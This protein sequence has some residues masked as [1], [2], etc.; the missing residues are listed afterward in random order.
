MCPNPRDDR[1]TCPTGGCRTPGF[2]PPRVRLR[3]IPWW[4]SSPECATPNRSPI[5][6]RRSRQLRE[7]LVASYEHSPSFLKISPSAELSRSP[8][9]LF[10][11]VGDLL[12]ASKRSSRL[13]FLQLFFTL[14]PGS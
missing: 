12:I 5:R 3:L 4:I 11:I 1:T 7:G 14:C 13:H 9:F 2:L 8:A 6:R 10:R